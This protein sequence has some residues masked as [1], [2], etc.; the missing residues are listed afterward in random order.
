[1]C[2]VVVEM[3]K[4]ESR[5][6]VM[7]TRLMAKQQQFIVLNVSGEESSTLP[8]CLVF[9]SF[10]PPLPHFPALCFSKSICNRPAAAV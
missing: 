6:V 5:T 1:M 7:G 9:L 2:V 10:L 4:S 8:L 3:H